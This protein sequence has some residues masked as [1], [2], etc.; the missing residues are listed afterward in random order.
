MRKVCAGA[1]W[2]SHYFTSSSLAGDFFSPHRAAGV[3]VEREWIP[4]VDL[5]GM[6]WKC[7]KAFCIFFSSLRPSSTTT[8]SR[9]DTIFHLKLN[10][11]KWVGSGWGATVN[12]DEIAGV[13]IITSEEWNCEIFI[14]LFLS[15]LFHFHSPPPQECFTMENLLHRL[16]RS[17]L[18]LD[19]VISVCCRCRRR[20]RWSRRNL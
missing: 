7:G 9:L 14:F 2:Q 11:P 4:A 13:E 3:W 8:R 16:T 6:K 5:T 15:L 20:C 18:L 10:E 19:V 12:D 1:T 17:Q